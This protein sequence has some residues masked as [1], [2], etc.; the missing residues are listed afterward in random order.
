M[1]S[2]T[3]IF[4]S[5][6]ALLYAAPVPSVKPL[7][8]C[9]VLRSPVSFNG[10]LVSIRGLLRATDHGAWIVG[11][12][13]PGVLTTQGYTWRSIIFLAYP[14][15]ADAL[16]EVDFD[17]D[18]EARHNLTMQIE[19][20]SKTGYDKVLVT[21]VGM[22]ETRANLDLQIYRDPSG[23]VRPAGFGHMVEAPAQVVVKTFKDPVF[24]R[25]R[26]INSSKR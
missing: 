22:L 25:P 20:R 10:K 9:E 19:Q 4:V 8:V 24:L 12:R 23:G 15:S 1:L 14:N 7:D 2:L 18:R 6:L 13:C 21:V 5:G 11:E 17:C 16:H 3:A 26:Q